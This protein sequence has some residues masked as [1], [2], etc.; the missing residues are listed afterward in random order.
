MTVKFKRSLFGYSPKDLAD[1]LKSMDEDFNNS[2]KE[3][4]K[5][6]ADEVHHLELAKL[7][8]QN[9]K[10]EMDSYKSYENEISKVLLEA[11]LEATEKFFEALK[12]SERTEKNAADKVLAR[13]AELAKLK[14]DMEQMKEEIHSIAG[15]YKL[16]LD[17]A[18]GE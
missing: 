18:E 15:Q 6:L 7:E 14:G 4:R 3:L 1:L 9:V 17:K 8:F 10:N 13:K 16:I 5:Q 11:H 12:D 2:L